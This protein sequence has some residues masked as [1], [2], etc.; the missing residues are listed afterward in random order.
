MK[1]SSSCC[2]LC[3]G[4]LE[5]NIS[6]PRK[7]S[8]LE[9]AAFIWQQQQN[10]LLFFFFFLRLNAFFFFFTVAVQNLIKIH[11]SPQ[12]INCYRLQ[13]LPPIHHLAFCL[14]S[15][16][17]TFVFPPQLY[18]IG[19]ATSVLAGDAFKFL[20]LRDC[21]NICF[22]TKLHRLTQITV[23]GKTDAPTKKK[24]QTH[25]NNTLIQLGYRKIKKT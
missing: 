7:V 12:K 4:I 9:G 17:E 8:F 22:T 20:R 18:R 13:H 3:P 24:S 5:N 23:A 15:L 6:K 10:V 16:W 1:A 14:F 11:L 19:E 21:A 2:T 25:E